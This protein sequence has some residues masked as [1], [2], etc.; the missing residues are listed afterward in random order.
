MPPPA[1]RSSWY[2]ATG[3]GAADGVARGVG[4]AF[5]LDHLIISTDRP[6]DPA[7]SRYLENTATT[8]GK[9][10]LPAEAGHS[11]TVEPEDVD[12][13]VHG[14]LGV[15]RYLEMLPGSAAPAQSPVWIENVLTVTSAEA[16]VFYPLVK[17]GTYVAKDGALG[18]VTG[19]FRRG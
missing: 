4:V 12:A 14:C 6:K 3:R 5:G 7:A 10:S 19:F 13:L 8:L 16:G 1:S 15:M 17:R 9:P 18:Y 2:E 11:G